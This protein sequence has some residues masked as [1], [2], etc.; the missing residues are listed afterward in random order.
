MTEILLAGVVLGLSGWALDALLGLIAT[1][2]RWT[3]VA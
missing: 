1:R 3:P 2:V